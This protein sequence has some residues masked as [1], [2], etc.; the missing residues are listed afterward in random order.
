MPRILCAAGGRAENSRGIQQKENWMP[1][2]FLKL[3]EAI[4]EIRGM[5][6]LGA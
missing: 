3:L 4:S 5:T 2:E 1:L 6:R